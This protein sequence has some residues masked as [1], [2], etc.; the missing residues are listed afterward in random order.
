MKLSVFVASALIVVATVASAQQWELWNIDVTGESLKQVYGETYEFKIQGNY[1]FHA[2]RY[3]GITI[4]DITDPFNPEPVAELEPGNII[5]Q[6]AV[7]DQYLYANSYPEDPATVYDVSDPASPQ[8]LGEVANLPFTTDFLELINGYL[9]RSEDGE[10]LW[11][12]DISDPLNLQT[13]YQNGLYELHSYDLSDD[14]NV[15]IAAHNIYDHLVTLDISNPAQIVELDNSVDHAE[16]SVAYDS[17]V[18]YLSGLEDQIR[19][20]EASDLANLGTVYTINCPD[21]SKAMT[22]TNNRLLVESGYSLKLFSVS[23]TSLPVLTG[24]I[25]NHQA[26]FLI[27]SPTNGNVVYSSSEKEAI[28]VHG[29]ANLSDPEWLGTAGWTAGFRTCVE[30]QGNL[31]AVAAEEYGSSNGVWVSDWSD[32]EHPVDTH[33]LDGGRIADMVWVGNYLYVCNHYTPVPTGLYVFDFTDPQNPQQIRYFQSATYEIETNGQILYRLRTGGTVEAYDV[34][35]PANPTLLGEV[36]GFDPSDRFA[37]EDENLYVLHEPYLRKYT[38]S[39]PLNPTLEQ[40][41]NVDYE[42]STSRYTHQFSV[43][44]SRIAICQDDLRLTLVDA[45]GPS[46]TI[47]TELTSSQAD[48]TG[49]AFDGNQLYA[50]IVGPYDDCG[51]HV[52]NVST[53][54]NPQEIASLQ[55]TNYV[56]RTVAEGPTA[57]AVIGTRLYQ[58]DLSSVIGGIEDPSNLT[59][60]LDGDGTVS[61]AWDEPQG[62]GEVLEYRIY[63]NGIQIGTSATTTYL[64]TLPGHGLFRYTVTALFAGGESNHTDPAEVNWLAPVTLT[65]DPFEPSQTLP[66]F[67]GRV[68][69]DV[70]LT[71]ALP[72]T[73]IADAWTEATLPGGTTVT[74]AMYSLE[75][76]PGQT[77]ARQWMSLAVPRFAPSGT[78]TF[79]AKVGVHPD[80]V[81]TQDTFQFTKLALGTTAS[82]AART[83][84][85]IPQFDES[86]ETWALTGWDKPNPPPSFARDL[87]REK[88]R[89]SETLESGE[90]LPAAFTL[91]ISPNPFNP[92]F[93]MTL[94]LPSRGDVRI[95]VVD[96][97][98]RQVAAETL[99]ERG[100]G[101][102][103]WTFDAGQHNLASGLYLV[104]VWYGTETVTRKAMLLK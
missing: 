17:G 46:L 25:E 43:S 29:V 33:I 4:V 99:R 60:V 35:N 41:L 87:T 45:R 10:G 16:E 42:S 103:K 74:V 91:N 5:W 12:Y 40:S 70:T 71:N 48:F 76:T 19:A 1:L 64:D 96:V 66:P 15:L 23:G 22:V 6:M 3:S 72:E 38:V 65:L 52:Y 85:E 31:I 44:D 27:P 9:Y 75:L 47:A 7:N 58:L 83:P 13:V 56:I 63:R 82:R 73:F 62:G 2:G 78:Y 36:N 59:A 8:Y 69:F 90:M 97:L 61:I 53:L 86:C 39:S 11:V 94:Q 84:A 55:G 92:S 100:A 98:G 104:Q 79:T 28:A 102:T 89:H 50:T 30:R 101:Q 37:M 49:G 34:A 51:L 32:P 77:F 88:E 18:I 81:A 93:T 26:D 68:Y 67:G 57:W 95:R 14:G 24:T 54:T 21:G 80:L 20:V